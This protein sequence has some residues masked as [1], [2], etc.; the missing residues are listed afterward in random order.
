MMAGA[1]GAVRV[2]PKAPP[3][4]SPGRGPAA[5]G[6]P[7]RP[8]RKAAKYEWV[9]ENR[10]NEPNAPLRGSSLR[11][12]TEQTQW[13]GNDSG[14]KGQVVGAK[15]KWDEG[16]AKNRENEPN[17]GARRYCLPRTLWFFVALLLLI[18]INRGGPAVPSDSAPVVA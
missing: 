4:P 2:L 7:S 15:L 11:N 1:L 13:A 8:T 10:E 14:R 12:F 5:G 16:V 17:R 9:A 6:R 18:R 3:M